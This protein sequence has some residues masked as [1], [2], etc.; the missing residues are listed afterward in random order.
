M[1]RKMK[2]KRCSLFCF[3]IRALLR[4]VDPNDDSSTSSRSRN[5]S[6]DSIELRTARQNGVVVIDPLLC[7]K[8]LTFISNDNVLKK[9]K[10]QEKRGCETVGETTENISVTEKRATPTVETDN[11]NIV[12]NSNGNCNGSPPDRNGL[13]LLNSCD[14]KNTDPNPT[15]IENGN[16]NNHIDNSAPCENGDIIAPRENG[17]NSA[18]CE[19]GADPQSPVF[20]E[21]VR[22]NNIFLALVDVEAEVLTHEREHFLALVDEATAASEEG[23]NL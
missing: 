12:L 8:N 23:R 3:Q 20:D 19:N 17:N 16:D 14:T 11:S 9:K 2:K 21:E 10:G 15:I 5:T 22:S 6:E 4:P 1:P 18:P 13:I 7:S